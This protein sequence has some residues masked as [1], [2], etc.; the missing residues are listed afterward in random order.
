[1]TAAAGNF[2]RVGGERRDGRRRRW[3]RKMKEEHE[4]QR[5]AF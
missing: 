5:S 4:P 3:M 2:I 1:M